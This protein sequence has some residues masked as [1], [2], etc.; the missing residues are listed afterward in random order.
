MRHSKKLAALAVAAGVAVTASAA[1]GWWST[2]GG[3]PGAASTGSHTRVSV[4]QVGSISGLVP[5]GDAQPIDF[6]I[7]NSLTTPQYV[8]SVS[9]AYDLDTDG[10]GTDTGMTWNAGCSDAD[11]TLVQPDPIN[12][13][14]AA[15]PHEF[16]PSG[17]SLKLDD[18][19]TR[20]Q[21]GCKDQQIVLSFSIDTVTVP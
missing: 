13:D 19:P 17:A 9:I 8:D 4:T 18:D 1:C 11:F 20:N 16:S 7:N 3:G 14:L 12:Q 2:D 6:S 5:D 10:D 15:G 21:D